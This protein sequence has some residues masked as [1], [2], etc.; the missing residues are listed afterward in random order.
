CDPRLAPPI[1][2]ARGHATP[3]PGRRATSASLRARGGVRMYMVMLL[4][5]FFGIAL[6]TGWV[7]QLLTGRRSGRIDWTQA[8]WVGVAGMGIAW[9]VARL[10]DRKVGTTFR[11]TVV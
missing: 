3:P 9:L 4:C 6:G 2:C 10:R 7:A 1:A 11:I 8:F 5:V